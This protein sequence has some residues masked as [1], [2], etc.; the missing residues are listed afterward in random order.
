M[1]DTEIMKLEFKIDQVLALNYKTD[2]G[3]CRERIE[4]LKGQLKAL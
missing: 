4:L 3:M 1:S 2:V